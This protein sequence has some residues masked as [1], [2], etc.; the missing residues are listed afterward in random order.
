MTELALKLGREIA[1]PAEAWEIL[2]GS[3]RT[4]VA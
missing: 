3:Q 2:G 4:R 1:T